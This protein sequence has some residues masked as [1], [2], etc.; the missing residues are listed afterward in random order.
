MSEKFKS[1]KF[2]MALLAVLIAFCNEQFN[3]GMDESAVNQIVATIGLYIIG[4][5][6][7]D[8]VGQNADAKRYDAY[9]N[10]VA[11]SENDDGA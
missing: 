9:V 5:G 10:A 4:Q 1:R 11:L 8:A 2:W 3:W 7:V 6:A